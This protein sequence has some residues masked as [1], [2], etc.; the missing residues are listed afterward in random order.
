M[1][2]IFVLIAFTLF[3]ANCDMPECKNTNPI[4]DRYTVDSKEYKAELVKQLHIVP[5]DKLSYRID[6]YIEKEGKIYMSIFIQGP[7]LCAK[8]LFDITNDSS[9]EYYRKKKGIGYK[10]AELRGLQ[11]IIDS[12]NGEPNLICTNA[13]YIVD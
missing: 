11:Y 3:F 9:L 12:T 7:G 13:G 8:G 10:G 6:E 4:F 2:R 1:P 5:A